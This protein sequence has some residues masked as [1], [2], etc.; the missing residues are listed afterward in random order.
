MVF[1]IMKLV[2]YRSFTLTAGSGPKSRLRCLRN[3]VPQESVPAPLMFNIY[4]YDLPSATASKFAYA[5]DL[6]ILHVVS[7]WQSLEKTL[8][9]DMS[10]L[11][12]YL[13]TW[14]LKLSTTK[15]VLTAFHL[16]NREVRRELNISVEGLLSTYLGVKPDRMRY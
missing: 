9:Q 8:N 16:I 15:T 11:P 5:D 10:T 7:N 6:A 3:G 2:R 12:S 1:L 4:M 14:K 13:Q